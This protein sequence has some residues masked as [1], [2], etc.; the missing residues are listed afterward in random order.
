M[1]YTLKTENIPFDGG[2]ITVRGLT[3]P[4]ISQ[5]VA[6][7]QDTAKSIYERF[8][9]KGA[10]AVSEQ[11]VESLALEILGTFPAAVAHL[12]WLCDSERGDAVI[13]DYAVLPIDVQVATL[14]KIATLTFAM[15]GGLE[16]FIATVTRIAAN[17][18]GLSK[19]LRK[20]QA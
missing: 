13:D 5:L 4:D 12:I 16:N 11:T 6:V 18:G 10:E 2:E 15:Q 9:G 8:S 7:H 3:V 20:P 19:E 14:E 17:A 1:K